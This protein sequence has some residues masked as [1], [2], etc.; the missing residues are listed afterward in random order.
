MRLN[1]N[2]FKFFFLII[3]LFKNNIYAHNFPKPLAKPLFK[4]RIYSDVF[5]EVK[6]QN[7]S[8]AKIL[9]NEYE[10]KAL[11]KYIEWLDITRP[12]SKKK[13][14]YLK[15]FLYEN[16]E[17]PKQDNIKRKIEESIGPAINA[18]DIVNYFEKNPPITI[19]GTIDL[20]EAQI[21]LGI[22]EEKSKI[23]RD[24]WIN[25]N[26]TF[27]QQK[28]FIKK[29]S[30]VWNAADNWKRFDRLMWE[31]KTFSAKKTLNRIKGDYRRLGNARIGLST[32]AP[33]VSQLISKVPKYLKTDA[34][35]IYERM[36]WRRKNKLDTATEFLFDPPENIKNYRNWWINSRI[37]I[38]RLINK[39]KYSTAYKILSNHK[40]PINTISGAEAEWLAGWVSLKFLKNSE[41]AKGHFKNLYKN[42]SHPRSKSKASFWIARAL[43]QNNQE[44]YE[45][46]KK[47]SNKNFFYGQISGIKTNDF[48]FK[49]INNKITK[50]ECCN[51]L[52]KIIK[53]LKEANEE[54][55]SYYFLEKGIELSKNENEKRY[56]FNLANNLENKD[57]LVKLTKKFQ[58]YSIEY[59]YPYILE[60][61][62]EQFKE[63][64][65]LALIHSIILQESA[66][67]VNAYSSA[68]ARGLMQLM[69]YTAKRVAQSINEKYYRKALMTNPQYNILLGTIYIKGLIKRF[70]G[71]IPLAL[72]GYNAGP[73]RVKIWLKRYGDPR[74]NQID[75][76]D[77][78]ESIPI[79]ETRNY[80][81]K[82]ISNYRVYKKKMGIKI[83]DLGYN[84]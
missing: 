7:W 51:E 74:K 29:Y 48:N 24:I 5:L 28:Y 49:E 75:Y 10:N 71:S 83:N 8:M 53:I 17:L 39:K 32:R 37:V 78:I 14:K 12:G 76:V 66:F 57:F 79:S 64:K 21:K 25:K 68:G 23:I 50:P 69:P 36:R 60:K 44:T 45:W 16:P 6:K 67:K 73:G 59:S 1:L 2:S 43:K 35:L 13:F 63:T 70:G 38:R 58:H 42:V 18:A 47:S 55:R 61:I 3:F 20:L 62:P 34:G 27:Q 82:V 84:Y 30:N 4:E 46:L 41:K 81:K 54:R 26:L 19:K 52:I 15:N 77:W 9:A 40:I 31:G 65:D 33:N 80:V 56:F 11:I 72:A 22:I